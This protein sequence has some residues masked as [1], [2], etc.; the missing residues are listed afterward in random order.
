MCFPQYIFY[1]RNWGR[2]LNS[3][4]ENMGGK[5]GKGGKGTN[6]EPIRDK[7]KSES[8]TRMC[9]D[10]FGL[11]FVLEPFVS[12]RLTRSFD[13]PPSTTQQSKETCQSISIQ[14]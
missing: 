9:N 11:Y 8:D 1:A 4:P 10:I 7:R 12:R 6:R 2:Y 3:V 14:N 13:F 5:G